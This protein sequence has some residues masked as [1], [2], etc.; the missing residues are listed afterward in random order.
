ME[1]GAGLDKVYKLLPLLAHN[2]ERRGVALD[3]K[4]KRGLVCWGL[5]TRELTPKREDNSVERLVNQ[6]KTPEARS[7]CFI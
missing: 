6:N 1:A 3:G 7:A 5:I 4:L 2:R